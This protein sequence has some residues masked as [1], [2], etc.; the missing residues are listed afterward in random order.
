MAAAPS[1]LPCVRQSY[2]GT[3]PAA[4]RTP[5]PPPVTRM[6]GATRH[7]VYACE[8]WEL[9][10]GRRELR[11]RGTPVVLGSRAFEIVELLARAGGQLV[12]KDDLMDRIW[13][14]AVVGDNTLHVHIAAVRKALGA[15]RDMLKTSPGRGYRL[16][17]S[18]M[19]QPGDAAPPLSPA[20]RA[21]AAERPPSNFPVIVTQLVGRSA[22]VQ[23]V[24]DLVSAYRIV[25]LTGAGGIGKTVLA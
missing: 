5:V 24:R 1:P 3:A 8:P 11:S 6:P 7:L 21:P 20:P 23:R 2:R 19:V 9:D 10:V 15:D 12:T 4:R 18:W 13:P 25:T 22:A 17:G 16:L 14:G